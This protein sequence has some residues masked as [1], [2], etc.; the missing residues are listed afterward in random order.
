[1]R[2]FLKQ[3][4]ELLTKTRLPWYLPTWLGGVG[5][6][7][8]SWG[9]CTDLDL[10]LARR[11]LLNWKKERPLDL[12]GKE[13]KWRTWA[14]AVEALP[15]PVYLTEKCAETEFYKSVVGKKCVDLLFDAQMTP[16]RFMLLETENTKVSRAL[17]RNADLYKPR[18]GLLPPPLSAE[19][20]A[21]RQRYPAYLM[22]GSFKKINELLPLLPRSVG[23][24]PEG[25]RALEL[26]TPF[27]QNQT[28]TQSVGVMVTGEAG[29]DS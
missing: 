10:R 28:Q 13:A 14:T 21:F 20:L 1:M 17:R 29:A 19:D 2:A 25:Q 11:V 18:G 12:A 23:A 5:L 24:G 22:P 27:L 7:S 4:K 8:G 9:T 15:P 16:Q 6:P 3:H 26:Q